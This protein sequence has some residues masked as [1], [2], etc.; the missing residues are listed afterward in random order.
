VQKEFSGLKLIKYAKSMA[1][2]LRHGSTGAE[3]TNRFD[4]IFKPSHQKLKL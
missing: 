4:L 3:M 2:K 1:Q